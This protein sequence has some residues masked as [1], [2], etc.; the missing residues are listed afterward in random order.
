MLHYVRIPLLIEGPHLFSGDTIF[1]K[2]DG[3][4]ITTTRQR[5]NSAISPKF[6]PGDAILMKINNRDC[7]DELET[8]DHIDN[9][10]QG[11]LFFINN[12]IVTV[13]SKV[14][15][16]HGVCDDPTSLSVDMEEPLRDD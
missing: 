1:L 14:L 9:V 2:H 4:V 8:F 13:C 6:D 10:P 5:G 12:D 3:F 15:P 16:S 7:L 11:R